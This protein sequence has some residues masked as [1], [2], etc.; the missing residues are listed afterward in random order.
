MDLFN[1][2]L[3]VPSNLRFFLHRLAD[4]AQ[5]STNILKINAM[6]STSASS[7]GLITVRLPMALVDLNSFAMFFQTTTTNGA[8]TN[9]GVAQA[10]LPKGIEALISRMEVSVNGL[11]LLNLQQY[12]LLYDVLKNSHMDMDKSVMRRTL[13]NECDTAPLLAVGSSAS[14]PGAAATNAHPVF[15]SAATFGIQ[16]AG[17]TLAITC[18]CGAL[19]PHI[20]NGDLAG[21]IPFA[22]LGITLTGAATSAVVSAVKQVPSY[23]QSVSVGGTTSYPAGGLVTQFVLTYTYATSIVTTTAY[24]ATSPA[25]FTVMIGGNAGTGGTA[26]QV[27]LS[28]LVAQ[29]SASLQAATYV[30]QTAPV[31]S[32]GTTS[33]Y[34]LPNQNGYHCISDWLS[35]F[36]AQPNWIQ[37]QMLGEVEIRLTLAGNDVLLTPPGLGLTSRPD[38]SMS[39][40]FFTIRTCSFDNNF[41]DD[42]LS[43]KLSSGGEVEIPYANYYNINQVQSA[44]SSSTRF[45][46]NTQ[47]LNKIVSVNRP[48]YYNSLAGAMIHAPC[49]YGIRA[50]GSYGL[51]HKGAYFQTT[52]GL[53]P[54]TSSIVSNPNTWQYQVNS[55]FIPNVKI[56]PSFAFY[57]HLEA[58]NLHNSWSDAVISGSPNIFL[59]SNYQ[60][61]IALDFMDSSIPRLCSGVDTRGAVSVAYLL[62]DDNNQG[63]RT[64]I[65]T[66]FTSVLK[67]GANQ[68]IQVIY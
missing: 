30:S 36:K 53:E 64:D 18:N 2:S 57:N 65:F 67:C 21:D 52:S 68:Q 7:G 49:G 62:Q 61:A 31:P 26:A 3:I 56:D 22:A 41:Y 25:T 58:W 11:G 46:V 42:I 16:A 55:Q 51:I 45:S 28:G 34:F 38:Y 40:I 19:Y 66:C 47:C 10:I 12:N 8:F 4:D 6:N 54:F 60:M 15:V 48:T 63:D 5:P 43:E 13:Q 1:E 20:Q 24:T 33:P 37:L 27:P 35:F 50:D 59:L 9:G 17:T 23:V 29:P 39:N 32:T 44:G 14:V